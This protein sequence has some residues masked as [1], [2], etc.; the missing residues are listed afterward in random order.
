MKI[1]GN[2]FGNIQRQTGKR[3]TLKIGSGRGRIDFRLLPEVDI[4]DLHMPL[5]SQVVDQFRFGDIVISA[6]DLP[7][8]PASVLGFKPNDLTLGLH[9]PAHSDGSVTR[10]AGVIRA[11]ISKT[12]T[13]VPEVGVVAL[14]SGCYRK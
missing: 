10:G 5:K 9:P 3:S 2:D 14:T 11:P 8:L 13:C 4:Y 7:S 1:P 6:I 12:A